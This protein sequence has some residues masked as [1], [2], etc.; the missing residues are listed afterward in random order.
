M[1]RSHWQIVN[2]RTLLS[3]Y[4]VVVVV[5]LFKV[6]CNLLLLLVRHIAFDLHFCC[7]NYY[8]RSQ[9]RTF[10]TNLVPI[11]RALSCSRDLLAILS[12]RVILFFLLNLLIVCLLSLELELPP[13]A[14]WI[15]GDC[16]RLV[17]W[18]SRARKMAKRTDRIHSFRSVDHKQFPVIFTE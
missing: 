4:Q 6:L 7:A 18:S 1:E 10:L 8:S 2:M 17:D 9:L 15:F 11:V 3:S 5:S 12:F 14:L 16:G 13:F